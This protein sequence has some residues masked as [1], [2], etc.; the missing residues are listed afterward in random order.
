[1]KV[2]KP[3]IVQELNTNKITKYKDNFIVCNRLYE[4]ITDNHRVLT[5][6]I[7]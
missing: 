7:K 4:L 2:A 6:M 5:N 1:M 3:I